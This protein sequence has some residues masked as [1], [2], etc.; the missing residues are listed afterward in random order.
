M[1]FRDKRQVEEISEQCAQNAH[2]VILMISDHAQLLDPI[3][4]LVS[5]LLV[6]K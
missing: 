4:S 3:G 1:R 6:S 5:T 2:L